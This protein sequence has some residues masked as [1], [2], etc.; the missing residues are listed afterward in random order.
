V[1]SFLYINGEWRASSDGGTH[2][3]RSPHDGALIAS[4]PQASVDDVNDAIAAARASFDSGIYSSWSWSKRSALVS[5]LADLLERD[6]A[7][8]AKKESDDTGKR[9][10]EAEYDVADVVAT[11]RH[12]A[13]LGLQEQDH[14][15]DVGLQNVT[16]RIVHE[17]IG[18]CSLIGPWNY[19]LL[20]I[21]WKVAPALVAGC[22][23]ILKPS[24][25][26]PQSAIHLIKLIEEAGAPAGVANLI[27]GP[28]SVVGNALTTDPRVDMVSFTGG[29]TTGKTIMVA[30]AAT[31]KKLA[32]ELGG[33]N[34]H[35]IFADADIDAAIDNAV[36]GA[37]LHS[38]QV[39]SAGT[40]LIV[41]RSIHD[42][43]VKEIVRRAGHIRMGGPSDLS[44]ET[45]PLISESH[46]KGVEKYVAAGVAEGAKLLVGG[47]RSQLPEHAQGWYFLPTVFDEC[48]TSMHCVQ[49]ESFGPVMTVEIFDT[50]AQ[51]IAIGNDTIFGLSGGL[52]TGD[53]LKAARVA[54]ALRHGTVWVNDYGPYR[55]QAEWGGYKQ[56]G[57][58]RELGSHG[59]G[60][61]LE[62]K[63]IWTNNS[64]SKSGWFHDVT[65]GER[66]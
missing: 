11:F 40:R 33:K 10:I 17:P 50:E 66:Q 52:W 9:I 8:I 64:P 13:K 65:E 3:I 47:A 32:L 57:I 56:S 55:P 34:P 7:I 6:A 43:V 4:V 49:E 38:G 21:A 24:E 58:G 31:V 62:I 5:T 19:P 59:L 61:Y 36:T 51:A 22:S 46:L 18:V 29:L 26:T 12:F 25:L 28:G 37:F 20:Q 15:V 30:A 16:S 39:C 63:H 48:N 35:I 53:S 54:S 1:T 60:E 44:A 45:G 2:E 42:R 27:L 41:E 23:F 14:T